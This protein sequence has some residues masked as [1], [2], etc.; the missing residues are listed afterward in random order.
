MEV[1]NLGIVKALHVGTNPP[2]NL[3]MLWK[4]TNPGVNKMKEWDVETQTWERLSSSVEGAKFQ[5]DITAYLGNGETFGK[6]KNGDLVP[7]K[8]KTPAQVIQDALSRTIPPTYLTPTA[9]LSSTPGTGNIEI[10]TVLNILL[11]ATFNQ[12]NGGQSTGLSLKKNGAQISTTDLFTDENV[13]IN[14]VAK[15]YTV[16]YTYED[17]PVLNNNIGTPDP[18][19]KILAGST[20]SA[21]VIFLGYRRG[22]YGCSTSG[23]DYD[24]TTSV[25]IRSLPGSTFNP[26]KGTKFTINIP[27]GAT[28][29]IF[30]YPASI[31]AVD[32]VKYVEFSNSEVKGIFTVTTV[33][34]EGVNGYASV[35]YNVCHYVPAQPY[36]SAVTYNVTI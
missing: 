9:S 7:A 28:E 12:R 36:T 25:G 13:L 11:D 22:F 4:D 34:V 32:S 6:Y 5:D 19:G 14:E 33:N 15:K 8:G 17:G 30:A 27:L 31:G 3:N 18:T 2:E 21:E 1:N 23:T 24:P 16:T 35:P 26:S 29:V 10:G 20:T